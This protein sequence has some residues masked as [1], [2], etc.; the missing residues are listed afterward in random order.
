MLPI[1][2]VTKLDMMYL[3]SWIVMAGAYNVELLTTSLKV[4][5][6]SPRSISSWKSMRTAGVVS[7]VNELALSESV[8]D[9]GTSG[10]S[11]IS[12]IIPLKTLIY[13]SSTLVARCSSESLR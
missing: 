2:R 10:L 8:Y 5:C 1:V 4:K 13:V 7:G 6:K 11:D 12:S 9:M 3:V